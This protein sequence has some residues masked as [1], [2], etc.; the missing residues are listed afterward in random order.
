M[1]IKNLLKSF[2]ISLI[3]ILVLN[4]ILTL[5]NYIG[6]INLNIINILKYFIP[7]IA[8]FIGGNIIGKNSINK[9]WLEGLKLGLLF[10]FML[11]VI[12]FF[13]YDMDSKQIILYMIILFSSILGSIV[14]I[15][16]KKA[17]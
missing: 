4:L 15:N 16:Q 9:G 17:N 14:G 3:S 11:F 12:N 6:L 13:F 1:N 10:S 2:L 8:L 5:L 7:F